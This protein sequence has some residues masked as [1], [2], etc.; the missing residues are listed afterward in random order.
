MRVGSGRADEGWCH[1]GHAGFRAMNVFHVVDS[2]SKLAAGPTYLISELSSYLNSSGHN[3][4]ILCVDGAQGADVTRGI[5]SF[6]QNYAG[7][8]LIGQLRFSRNLRD[9]L[10][11]LSADG[12]LLHS[13]GLWRMCNIYASQAVRNRGGR[14]VIS[15]HGMLG[16]KAVRNSHWQKRMFLAWYQSRALQAAHCYHAASEEEL[17]DIR[18]FGISQPVAVIPPGIQNFTDAE[19][20]VD[21]DRRASDRR[22]LLYLGRLH[23]QKGLMMLLDAW[24]GVEQKF[25][26][27]ELQIVGPSQHGHL[28]ELKDRALRLK[29][30]SVR[31]DRPLYGIQ[32]NLAYRL[33]DLFVLPTSGE[34][35][36]FAV[37]ESLANATPVIC[38][39]Q[40][41]WGGL[42]TNSCGWWIDRSVEDLR[43]VLLEA[44]EMPRSSLDRMGMSGRNWMEKDFSWNKASREFG[45][46]YRWVLFGG[47][48]P[49]C[50]QM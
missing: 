39:K 37:A 41:P 46:V 30:K 6:S 3:S 24:A 12:V 29:L 40:A 21:K 31:L 11:A 48:K 27:W 34:N 14:L 17:H 25:P 16:S 23:R 13:H 8:P 10:L 1:L 45:D 42:L 22:T 18:S 32:K 49:S 15:P 28:E 20:L 33:A 7:L 44:L 43:S 9:T 35:F 50:I 4:Q 2:I 36:G 47:D 38:T 26:D 5:L 19:I